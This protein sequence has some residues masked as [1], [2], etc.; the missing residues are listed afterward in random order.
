MVGVSRHSGRASGTGRI[1]AEPGPVDDG[2]VSC[3]HCPATVDREAVYRVPDPNYSVAS[4]SA[5]CEHHLAVLAREHPTVWGR[6][7]NH[8]EYG[9]VLEYKR[10]GALVERG[11]LPEE[12]E[13]DDRLYQRFGVDEVGRAYFVVEL[14]SGDYHLVETG[15][16]FDV[17]E[18]THV[19]R[20]GLLG[21]LDHVEDRH[22]WR[23]LADGWVDR[24]YAESGGDDA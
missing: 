17:L 2:D 7:K 4:V 21:L 12:I 11:D 23:G 6:L 1:V 16:E 10:D 3:D 18:E 5:L 9:D 20:G 22:G 14:G 13:H 19:P 8:D 24:A 15:H